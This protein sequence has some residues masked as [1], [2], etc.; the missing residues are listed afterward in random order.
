MSGQWT[1]NPFHHQ[2]CIVIELLLVIVGHDVTVGDK[3]PN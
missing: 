3:T 2:S 1:R